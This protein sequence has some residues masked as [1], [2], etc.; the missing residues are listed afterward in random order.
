MDVGGKITGNSNVFN[1][2]GAAINI[3][4]SGDILLEGNGTTGAIITS[5]QTGGSGGG[6]KGGKITIH[7]DTNITTEAGSIISSNGSVNPAGEIDIT[8]NVAIDI[9]G[10]VLSESGV[11][12]TGGLNQKPGGGPIFISAGCNFTCEDHCTISSKGADPGADLVHI[13]AGCDV[14][15]VGLVQSTA[16]GGA[17]TSFNSDFLRRRFPTRKGLKRGSLR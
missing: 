4:S 1:K 9:D 13:D 10:N 2:S 7:S 6:A 14:L 17:C 5:N 11:S 16:T 8:A 15:I 12:G 3:E